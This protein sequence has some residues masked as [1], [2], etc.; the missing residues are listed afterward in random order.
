GIPPDTYFANEKK[1]YTDYSNWSP[2]N[3]HDDYTGYYSMEGALAKSINTIA[4]DVAMQTGIS[5][6]IDLANRMGIK[7]ELPEY[8]SLALGTP[9][10][11]LEE[12]I[13][14]YSEIVNG[15]RKVKPY[16]LKAIESSTGQVLE[17][18]QNIQSDEQLARSENCRIIT[19]MLQSVIDGG[20]GSAIRTKWGIDGDFAGKTG[21]TQDQ[22]DGWFIGMTPKLVAGAW[23]GGEDQSVHF[24]TLG[25]G[26]GGHTALPIVGQFYS[27]IYRNSKFK[28]I[29]YSRFD[30]PSGET[31][32]MLD[33]PPYR[34]VLPL[35]VK[36][37][38][39]D[40]FGRK[41]TKQETDLRIQERENRK[42]ARE[43]ARQDER[44]EKK[45]FWQSM[46]DA[47][48]KKNK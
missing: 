8:P 25:A 21:T 37:F 4:V 12:M 5:N 35:T 24:R 9:S 48:K 13:C 3:S 26:A 33:I 42:Q 39:Q 31:L 29:R 22:A 41:D 40:L 44:S 32:A 1:V 2:S 46:K 23:V 19:H 45:P 10:V 15:G 43:E 38:F 27:Q 6:V 16:Y 47:F 28:D 17:E 7:S 11:S 34:E 18:F 30:Q 20:T 36:G 14:V